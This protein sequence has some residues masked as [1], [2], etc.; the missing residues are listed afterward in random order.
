MFHDPA[1]ARGIY[2]GTLPLDRVEVLVME[3][4]RL[5]GLLSNDVQRDI[6]DRMCAY[7]TN[8]HDVTTSPL[9]DV[10]VGARVGT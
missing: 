3:M 5:S 7:L 4:I 10:T 6:V 9:D 2:L 1:R 8:Q